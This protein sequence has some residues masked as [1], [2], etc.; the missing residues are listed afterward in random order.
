MEAAQDIERIADWFTANGPV[1]SWVSDRKGA[2]KGTFVGRW[3]GITATEEGK[4]FKA[5]ILYSAHEGAWSPDRVE[6][7]V[8]DSGLRD[9][10]TT[11][12]KK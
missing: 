3:P 12:S 8:N 2:P 7:E 4:V 1:P 10:S 5:R 6:R 11:Q 9:R